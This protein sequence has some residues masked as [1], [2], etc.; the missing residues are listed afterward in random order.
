MNNMK[1]LLSLLLAV[2]MVLSMAACAGNTDPTNSSGTGSANGNTGTYEVT[3]QSAGKLPLEGVNVEVYDDEAMLNLVDVRKTNAD[4]KASLNLPVGGS[5]RIKLS[6][7]PD[8]Y[9]V[10]ESYEVTG[11]ATAITLISAPIEGQSM[12][13]ASFELGDVIYDFEITLPDGTTKVKLSDMLAEKKMVVLNLFYTTCSACIKEMPYMIQAYE[14]NKEDVGIIA[15]SPYPNDNNALVQNFI[16]TYGVE[17]PTA[18]VP[19]GWGTL[20][21]EGYYPT[22]YVIDRYGVVSLIEIGAL[23]SLRPWVSMMEYFTADDFTQKLC[24][25]GVQD[26]LTK[27]EPTVEDETPEKLAEILGNANGNIVYRN[28][29]EDQYCW[30]FVSAEKNGETGLKSSNTAIEASYAILYMDV[31]LKKGEAIGLDYLISSE[32]GADYLHI[33]V[34]DTPI[35]QISGKDEVDTWKTCYPWVAQEDGV[36]KVGIVYMKDD[37]DNVGDDAAYIKNVRV[38]DAEDIDVETFLP[39]QAASSPDGFAYEYVDIVYNEADGYYH[40][41]SVNGPLLL[42]NLMTVSPLYEDTSVYLKALNG[43]FGD[44]FLE[45]VTRYASYAANS[46]LS[47]YCTVTKELAELLKYAVSLDG[48][49][50][51][52]NEWLKLCKFYNAYGTDRQQEDP[53]AGLAPFCA[54]PAQ[55]GMNTLPYWE[56]IPII[57][58]GKVAKFVPEKS[59][60]YRITSHDNRK[61]EQS[62]FLSAW[63]FNENHEMIHEA[64]AE[65]GF[66]AENYDPIVDITMVYYMEAGK[67][68]YIDI[69]FYDVY[70]VGEILY[71]I[72]YVGAGMQQLIQASPGPFTFIET[73]EGGMGE[74]IHGGINAVLNPVDGY[75]YH[76]LGKDA[77]GNQ[78]YGSLI[79]VDFTQTPYLGTSIVTAIGQGSFNFVYSEIDEVIMRTM[80]EHNNDREAVDA[81]LKELWGEEVYMQNQSI[82]ND[83]FNGIYHGVGADD[84]AD[85]RSYLDKMID[86]GELDGCVKMDENLAKI[87]QKLMDKYSFANVYQSWL[88]LC[89]YYN[90][91]GA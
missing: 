13:G 41:G 69:A 66:T 24:Y 4:G 75:Y 77:N 33:I 43:D 42:A 62:G 3:V 22:T 73:P 88:K 26:I 2:A 5:Y 53:I 7:T 21:V 12:S 31:T 19:T 68:Y 32:A 80:K 47:N 70:N 72:E 8:G 34:D 83:V 81:D 78:R 44:E 67:A 50:G 23:T 55:L 84:T 87:L 54:L 29:V 37:S 11:N 90:I 20:A 82:I 1:K 10:Q 40:V 6:G 49:D 86:G 38:V 18:K 71:E 79:Y 60:V 45:K 59:G 25:N 76:D 56:G 64:V 27:V 52:E 85:I 36:Y 63:I 58:R 15:L 9:K 17:Y 74:V 57:P 91:L 61:Y 28:E 65:E 35:Y 51:T 16:D 89:Y 39:Q 46:K 48:F 30:P 14:Q